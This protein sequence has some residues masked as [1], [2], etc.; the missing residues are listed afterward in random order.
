MRRSTVI[1]LVLMLSAASVVLM[2]PGSDASTGIPVDGGNTAWVAVC[3]ALVFIMT[4]GVALFYGGMLRKQSMTSIMAQTLI[5]TAIMTL[6]WVAVG[7]SLAF[8][9]DG[10]I[11]GGLDEVLLNG[12][13]YDDV[14][15]GGIPE[16]EFVM[17]QCAFALITAGIVIG[18]CAERIHFKA[19]ALFLVIW[20]VVVYAPM[21]HWVWGGGFF[22]EYFT[23]RDFAGG[24]VVHICAATTS[25]ALALFVGRRGDRVIKDRAH[26]LPLVFIGF[27]LLWF[28]WIGFNGGSGLAADGIATNAILVT[29]LSMATSMAVWALIQYFHVGHV[30]VLG[31]ISGGVAGLVAITPA[32]GYV[33][34]SSAIIIGA[35]GAPICYFGVLFMRRRSG[36][37]D[38]LDVF[39]VHGLGGI[40]GSV[41]TG[42]FALESMGGAAGL[43]EGSVDLFVGQIVAA[44]ITLVYC[45]AVS[46]ALIFLVSMIT[47]VRLSEDEEAIGADIMEHG[48]PSYII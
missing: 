35:V 34:A 11:V 31:L 46:Y 9:G 40:W 7:Y 38:A 45:F 44:V 15:E 32:A 19:I 47:P 23:V 10:L 5:V 29:Q 26:N 13:A 8:G 36:I 41:A 21:A 2:T 1:C 39:G 24:T 27:A 42:I 20:S 30:G 28:G 43:I 25:L 3:T 17:F 6:S 14:L 12:I 18:G 22:D 16:L 37:D 33:T 4:P 48:E